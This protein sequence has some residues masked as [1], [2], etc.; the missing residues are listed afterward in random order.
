MTNE[1]EGL[2]E[3]WIEQH[4]VTY[5]YAYDKSGK[6]MRELGVTGIP[7]AFLLN[8]AGE[9]VWQGHPGNLRTEMIVK[10]LEG[11]LEF[12]AFEWPDEAASIG[13]SV[14]KQDYAKAMDEADK[15]IE[16]DPS[17]VKY[18]E[19]VQSIVDGRVAALTASLQKGDFLGAQE[20]GKVLKK[21]LKGLPAADRVDEV[22]DQIAKDREAKA[23]ITAQK[24]LARLRAVEVRKKAQAIGLQRQA[25]RIAEKYPGT[26]VASQALSFI[27][28]LEALART[29]KS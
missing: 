14:L 12:P 17:M 20:T 2:T 16:A 7:H 3:K 22:L 19:K 5:A 15:L 27:E 23:I 28:E 26:F 13:K 8:P 24:T 29:L 18:R 4:D 25:E 1:P 10:H 11:A 6:L 9:I 21:D